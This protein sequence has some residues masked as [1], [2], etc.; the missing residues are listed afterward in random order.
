M[1]PKAFKGKCTKKKL[2]K[3]HEVARLYD[4][5]QIVYA[6][7]LDSDP[8]I[9]EI[10]VN[11]HLQDFSEGEFTTDFLCIKTTGEYCIRECVYRK[12]LQ[13]PRMCRLLDASRLYWLRR[14]IDDWAIVTEV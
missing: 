14:G 10:F 1:R 3:C 11:Y 5:L 9:K 2:S 12:K 4:N 8:D 6:E 7:K 13:L